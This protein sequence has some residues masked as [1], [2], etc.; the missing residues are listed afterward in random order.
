ME[1]MHTD[2]RVKR[3]NKGRSGHLPCNH[4]V[5]GVKDGKLCGPGED[6]ELENQLLFRVHE[7]KNKE[8]MR[9]FN[10]IP[11]RVLLT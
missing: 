6:T 5:I 11:S 8:S 9:I 2:V 1:N 3:V 4:S 7:I 10:S